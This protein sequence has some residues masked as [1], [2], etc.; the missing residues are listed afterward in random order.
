MMTVN[1]R[2]SRPSEIA[3]P[4]SPIRGFPLHAVLCPDHLTANTTYD[5]CSQY[6]PWEYPT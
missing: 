6:D 3:T 1:T 4:I 5:E 2:L